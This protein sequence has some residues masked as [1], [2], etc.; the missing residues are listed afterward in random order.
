MMKTGLAV[1]L[2]ISLA[3]NVFL[4]GFVAGRIAGGPPHAGFA[5]AHRRAPSAGMFMFR[6]LDALSPEGRAAF[7]SVFND[8]REEMR[9]NFREVMRLRKAFIDTLAADQWDRANAEKALDDLRKVESRQQTE[10]G[11]L[12]VDAFEKLPAK[13]RQALAKAAQTPRA[14]GRGGFARRHHRRRGEAMPPPPA[15]GDEPPPLDGPPPDE[16]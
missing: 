10:L 8:H 5:D 15:M 9:G 13:D 2:A 12:I 16:N 6:D 4:G 14:D 7:R 11:E 3:A 1:A